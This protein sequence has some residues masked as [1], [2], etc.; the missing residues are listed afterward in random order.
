LVLKDGLLNA[1]GTLSPAPASGWTSN[2]IKPPGTTAP[3]EKFV[4]APQLNEQDTLVQ[5]AEH[6]P[7]GKRTPMCAH[8]NQVIR[9]VSIR[10]AGSLTLGLCFAFMAFD[11][12]VTSVFKAFHF[13]N[14]EHCFHA[15]VI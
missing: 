7:A 15:W 12:L 13:S 14:A 3:S 5:R 10:P 8:C 11:S 2:S 9:L 4:T 1:F 6:I